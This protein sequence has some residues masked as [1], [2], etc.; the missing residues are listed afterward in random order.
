MVNPI[1]NVARDA[2][3]LAWHGVSSGLVSGFIVATYPVSVPALLMFSER[4]NKQ[5]DNRSD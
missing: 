1:L 3:Y 2:G 4:D 5:N